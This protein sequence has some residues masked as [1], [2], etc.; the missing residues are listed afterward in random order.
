MKLLSRR[1][2]R[3]NTLESCK[4]LHESN[5]SFPPT[6]D[7]LIG[8]SP[9]EKTLPQSNKSLFRSDK[10]LPQSENPVPQSYESV[11]QSDKS[12]PLSSRM[13]AQ[14]S[15]KQ[16][17]STEISTLEAKNV[18][19]KNIDVKK[20]DKSIGSASTAI[21]HPTSSNN[22]S[23]SVR[24]DS[25]SH[26][27]VR[28][29]DY[30]M[31]PTLLYKFIEYKEWGESLER[32]KYAQQEASTWVVRYEEESDNDSV[33]SESSKTVRWR[34]LPIHVA[35]IFNAPLKLVTAL[36]KAYP[37]GVNSTDDRKMLPIHLCCRVL[38]NINVATF[39]ITNNASTI[40]KTDYRGRTP[41]MMLLDY[42][43]K[44]KDRTD[45]SAKEEMKNRNVLIDLIE[46]KF[47]KGG[48]E[49]DRTNGGILS[50]NMT[51]SIEEIAARTRLM[52]S[53]KNDL[54]SV[55]STHE[56]KR[57]INLQVDKSTDTATGASKDARDNTDAQ[58]KMTASDNL[59]EAMQ[60]M[61]KAKKQEVSMRT[62]STSRKKKGSVEVHEVD[63]DTYPTKLIKLVEKKK[64]EEAIQRCVDYPQEAST[65][66]CRL[67]EI[68]GIDKKKKEVR[69]RILP[70]HSAIVLH[71][72]VEV[73][74]ALVDAYPDG[75]KTGDDRQ[76]L[77]LHMAFRLGASPETAAVLVDAYPD[78]LGMKDSKGHTPLH[79]L[80]AYRRKYEK[81]KKKGKRLSSAIDRN[82]KDLIHFYLGNRKYRN[83]S[84]S[85]RTK[86]D[87]TVEGKLPFYNS[88]SDDSD[89]SGNESE[90]E[91]D[92]LF[93]KDM[94][95]DFGRLTIE[96]FS[97]IPSVLK[98]TMSCR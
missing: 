65:W 88:A 52:S 73:I 15:V 22:S 64:W 55:T 9:S 48:R 93:H 6:D 75:I 74:E 46:T 12:A 78:A 38:S 44:S 13:V 42:K 16:D 24:D 57:T 71:A 3:G 83:Q 34:M 10:S 56:G 47:S 94:F 63:Y 2:K 61:G 90:E 70:L 45:E 27:I 29:V 77:P 39:L 5:P 89:S 76:M 59:A 91:Y 33:S 32:C 11:T 31:N 98:D 41:L 86:D 85:Q 67:Q 81:E 96:G 4:P 23:K 25:A 40:S 79:V 80:K 8:I 87:R 72:P 18:E 66:M 50:I 19:E 21:T 97:N 1:R 14:V 35:I 20:D 7:S 30:D 53:S 43:E 82:R 58:L 54:A 69:W 36:C 68:D 37:A 26:M 62:N 17:S 92:N 60:S 28:E 95:A 84:L 51:T 49:K